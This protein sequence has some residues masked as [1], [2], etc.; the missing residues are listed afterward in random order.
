MDKERIKK[1][2]TNTAKRVGATG[3][4]V[5]GGMAAVEAIGVLAKTQPPI[6][7]KALGGFIVGVVGGIIYM[8]RED[9]KTNS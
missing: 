5:L 2:L 1:G 3:L 9:N 4:G 7:A 8:L 6:E